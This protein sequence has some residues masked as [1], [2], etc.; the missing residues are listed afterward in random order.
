MTSIETSAPGKAVISGEYAVLRGAPAICM[1]IDRRAVVCLEPAEGNRHRL[2]APGYA[3]GEWFFTTQHGGRFTWHGSSP[4]GLFGL[5]EAVWAEVFAQRQPMDMLALTLDTR[6]FHD[7]STGYKLGLGSSAAITAALVAALAELTGQADQRSQ[8]SAQ[9]HYKFQ[10]QQGS[11]VDLASALHGGLIEY[12]MRNGQEPEAL[13]WPTDLLYRLIWTGKPI[14]TVSKLQRFNQIADDSTALQA[15]RA[16]SKEVAA[17]WRLK[18]TD[19]IID[20]M[21]RYTR[22]LRAFDK[23][24]ELGIF[25]GGHE[26][27]FVAAEQSQLVY[28]PCGAGG[29]DIGIA[30]GT[31]DE[32]LDAFVQAARSQ[33]L[34]AISAKMDSRGLTVSHRD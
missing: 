17:V 7:V 5:V 25:A 28:K 4:E 15:L 14:K 32:Q 19:E 1:A 6:A 33:G 10:A 21:R 23:T 27:G 2:T 11:G 30:I 16:I 29:G 26:T 8:L 34:T 9:A 22:L 12:S 31:S 13:T 20:S 24:E 18:V 3:D